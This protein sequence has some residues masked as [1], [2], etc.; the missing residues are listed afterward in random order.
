MYSNRGSG[1]NRLRLDDFKRI[2]EDAGFAVAFEE[3]VAYPDA[4]QFRRWA[5]RFHRDYASRDMD[6]LRALECMLV[7][8]KP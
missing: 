8:R 4:A 7:L 6:M 5:S 1:S 2:Y 3:V